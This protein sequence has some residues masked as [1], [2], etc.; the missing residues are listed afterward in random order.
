MEDFGFGSR[1]FHTVTDDNQRTFGRIN[2]LYGISSR[3]R[4]DRRNGII[5]PNPRAGFPVVVAAFDQGV[6]G[7]F[8]VDGAGASCACHIE[9]FGNGRHDFVEAGDLVVP[10]GDGDGHVNHV[11]FLKEIGSEG[12]GRYLCRNADHGGRVEHGIGNP[13]QQV[14]GPGA[15]GG[16]ADARLVGDARVALCGMHGSLFVPCQQVVQFGVVLQA[17]VDRCDA[18]AR[19][20]EHGLYALV[21]QRCEQGICATDVFF[22]GISHGCPW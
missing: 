8:D 11:R 17:V 13:G 6:F 18:A 14:C 20:A 5:A 10:F 9:G 19:V 2:H 3:L 15:R 22:I 7:D 21:Y 16:H 1:D 4:F 12:S